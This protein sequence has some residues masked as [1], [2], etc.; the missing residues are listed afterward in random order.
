[1]AKRASTRK[2]VDHLGAA[3]TAMTT[4]Q[5]Y[6]ATPSDMAPL[7]SDPRGALVEFN[8]QVRDGDKIAY[9]ATPLGAQIHANGG[10]GAPQSQPA[11]WGTGPANPAPSNPQAQ[12]G[13]QTTGQMMQFDT[14][15]AIPSPRRG[16]K[17]SPVYGFEHMSVGHS[18]FVPSSNDNPNP[19]KR[20]ASTVSSATKRLDPKKFVVRS[21]DETS[22]GRGKGARVWRTE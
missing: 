6:M 4:G 9:R 14:G 2:S 10:A 13:Q 15:I 8:D 22:Q 12:Q 21:V 20:I 1:M 7:L 3:V 5:P 17:G 19:A 18:F 11:A 16:G